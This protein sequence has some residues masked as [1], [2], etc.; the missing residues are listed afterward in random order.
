L[1]GL[2]ESGWIV[3]QNLSIDWRFSEG[4][5]GPLGRLAAELVNRQVEV[6]VTSPIEPT[7]AAKRATSN[8]PIVFVGVA[9]P[10]QAGI[11]TNLARP[12]ANVT[13][14]STLRTLPVS[15]WRC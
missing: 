9:D 7:I 1:D 10:I 4:G 6:I 15:G 3:G 13:G 14:M 2:R 8:I 12:D 11:V 5:A